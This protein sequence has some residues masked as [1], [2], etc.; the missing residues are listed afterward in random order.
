MT[1]IRDDS[2]MTLTELLVVSV[3]N[4]VSSQRPTSCSLRRSP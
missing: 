3:L 4:S 1:S 2:G